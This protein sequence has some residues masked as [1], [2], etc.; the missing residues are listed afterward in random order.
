MS[1]KKR[2]LQITLFLAVMAMTLYAL[3]RGHSL[4]EIAQAMAEMIIDMAVVDP[5]MF[6]G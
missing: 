2:A 5:F 3:F 6:A 4:A 1:A